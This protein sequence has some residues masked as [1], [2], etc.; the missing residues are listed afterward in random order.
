VLV[1]PI[2]LPFRGAIETIRLADSFALGALLFR[3]ADL[4]AEARR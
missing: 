1:G 3:L 2:D 4:Y